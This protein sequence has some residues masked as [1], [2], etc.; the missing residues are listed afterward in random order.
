MAHPALSLI[1]LSWNQRH[2]TERCVTSLRATTDVAYELIIVDNGSDPATV[3]YVHQAADVAVC[4]DTNLGFGPGMNSGL[5]VA[6]GSLV[7][8]INNDTVFPPGW[9]APVLSNFENA[10]VGL[11]VPAVTAAGNP[12][13]VRT[14]PGREA[15]TLV[16]FTEIPSGVVYLMRTDVAQALGGFD[17]RYEVASAED[18][19]L[20]FTVWANGLDVV[21][22]ERALIEHESQATVASQLSNRGALY[23]RN[24]DVFLD[25]WSSD[26]PDP[27]LLPD[28][29]R[30]LVGGRLREA[31]V[32]AVWLRRLV[33]ER[34]K[35]R[36]DI[37]E[38]ESARRPT[39]WRGLRSR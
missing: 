22:D 30:D 17:Q 25:R 28:V 5:A 16:P 10:G 38:L 2:L 23:R 37:A 34:R 21:L 9:T 4:H 27:A 32:A 20:L 1:V 36:Q 14:T 35:L 39:G 18:L 31:R 12:V 19:D 13:S 7:A 33:Y 26:V 6:G 8:F 15:I 3:D 24:L 11:V 29:D